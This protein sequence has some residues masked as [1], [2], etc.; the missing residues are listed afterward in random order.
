MYVQ[1]VIK[2]KVCDL[3]KGDACIFRSYLF[4]LISLIEQN[5]QL[6]QLQRMSVS[7]SAC[8]PVSGP[9]IAGVGVVGEGGQRGQGGQLPLPG[10]LFFFSNIVFD[11]VGL[12]LVVHVYW[13][14]I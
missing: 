14:K 1:C 4:F 8:L 6:K 11:F 3:I 7:V 10:K 12:F 13:S 9:Y 2:G 5:T